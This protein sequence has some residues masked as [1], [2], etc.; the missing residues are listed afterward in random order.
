M[1]E[2]LVLFLGLLPLIGIILWKYTC[3]IFPVDD[4][5]VIMPPNY[6]GALPMAPGY[7]VPALPI[8]KEGDNYY[9]F[10]EN[11]DGT[12]TKKYISITKLVDV[13]KPKVD[14]FDNCLNV[15]F[16][17]HVM[18]MLSED[19]AYIT[20]IGAQHILFKDKVERT[21]ALE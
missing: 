13:V 4:R 14:T 3:Y 16:N 18:I 9:T 10:F 6:I 21:K 7:P 15:D 12:S 5:K 17:K 19:S 1:T 20:K 2:L 11:K 8:H